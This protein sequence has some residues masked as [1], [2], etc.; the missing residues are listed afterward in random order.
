MSLQIYKK[1]TKQGVK[2]FKLTEKR[3]TYNKKPVNYITNINFDA[4]KREYSL[5]DEEYY[6][7]WKLEQ[8][9]R[10]NFLRLIPETTTT[11]FNMSEWKIALVI[12]KKFEENGV[13]FTWIKGALLNKETNKIMFKS[14]VNNLER[15]TGEKWTY[16]NSYDAEWFVTKSG[17]IAPLFFYEELKNRLIN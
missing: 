17:M 10:E 15:L 11:P 16:K 1:A 3:N 13:E 8:H 4:M 14:S 5:T 6:N 12:S 7:G 9:T 2:E